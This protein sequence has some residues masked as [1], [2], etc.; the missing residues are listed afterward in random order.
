MLREQGSIAAHAA[1]E[2]SGAD[3]PKLGNSKLAPIRHVREDRAVEVC[4]D[5]V[6]EPVI[7]CPVDVQ[8]RRVPL[9]AAPDRAGKSCEPGRRG[10][11]S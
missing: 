9:V 3:G 5:V 4:R 1:P 2:G 8:P 10:A 11:A 7:R 6:G